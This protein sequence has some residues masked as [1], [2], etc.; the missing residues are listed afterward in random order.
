MLL[1]CNFTTL[2]EI[3]SPMKSL[4]KTYFSPMQFMPTVRMSAAVILCFAFA[5]LFALSESNHG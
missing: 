5:D 2:S 3:I 4:I 1:P